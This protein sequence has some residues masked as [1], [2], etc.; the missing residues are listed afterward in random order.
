[1]GNEIKNIFK[2]VLKTSS[3]LLI[4]GPWRK[5]VFYLKYDYPGEI[6]VTGNAVN[7][8]L[9]N[10]TLQKDSFTFILE[11]YDIIR[12]LHTIKSARFSIENGLF[13]IA[14]NDVVLNPTTS[15]ELFIIAEIF[16]HGYYNFQCAQQTIVVDIGMNVG[17]CSLFFASRNDVEKIYGFEPFGPTYVQA[18]VNFNNNH[19]LQE[20]IVP[21][22][23]GLGGEEDTLTVDYHYEFKGQMGIY[24]T[25]RVK[26]KVGVTEKQTIQ[27]KDAAV[28]LKTIVENHPG[29]SFVLKVDC[30]GAEY[31]IIN[32][33][34]EANILSCFKIIFLE[35]HEQGPLSLV[36]T[37]KTFGFACFY[38]YSF[39]QKV[40]MIYASK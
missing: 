23:Y 26:S 2:K 16:L 27:I 32:R 21:Y 17:V 7:L 24:G 25:S 22:P 8:D 33:L 11:R 34:A 1:M 19:L 12:A 37:L 4:T 31:G 9:V 15:E 30:E 3:S 10:L 39:D 5:K 36:K 18:L 13:L 38:N 14:M 6:T 29:Y 40:G 28:E 20:K 35:W